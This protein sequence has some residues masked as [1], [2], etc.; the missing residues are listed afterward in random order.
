MLHTRSI[1]TCHLDGISSYPG[2][3]IQHESF[4]RLVA[5]GSA[6]RILLSAYGDYGIDQTPQFRSAS[7]LLAVTPR[8]SEAPPF[9]A[10]RFDLYA[11]NIAEFI[12]AH[13]EGREPL[14]THANHG[15]PI[16]NIEDV[17]KSLGSHGTVVFRVDA[18]EKIELRNRSKWRRNCHSDHVTIE[19][20]SAANV[21]GLKHSRGE[22]LVSDEKAKTFHPGDLINP[23]DSNNAKPIHRVVASLVRVLDDSEAMTIDMFGPD[24]KND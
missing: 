5:A 2:P 7:M 21:A 17:C 14:L 18:M 4:K 19:V 15:L 23:N 3:E 16:D 8:S 9:D 10:K 11:R 20:E 12:D 22:L 13:H 1:I 6:V 24:H